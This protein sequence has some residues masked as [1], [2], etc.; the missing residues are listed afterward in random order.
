MV[1]NKNAKRKHFVGPYD[2][3]NPTVAP[4]ADAFM[5]LAKGIT[6]SAPNNDEET[7]DSAYFDGDGTPTTNVI[8]KK[9]GRTFEGEREIGDKA[10]DFI[11][12]LEDKLGEDLYVWY[13]EITPDGKTQYEGVATVSGIEIGDGEASEYESFKCD[14]TWNSIP[15]KS[16]VLHG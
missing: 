10:Q 4:L 6:E 16:Q 2:K 9:R 14:I 3:E 15:K 7:D 12:D 5:W 8:S 1:K 13:K 11:A